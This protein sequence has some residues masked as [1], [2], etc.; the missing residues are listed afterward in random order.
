MVVGAVGGLEVLTGSR[1]GGPMIEG[2]GILLT[3]RDSPDSSICMSSEILAASPK[4]GASAGCRP[5]PEASRKSTALSNFA[6]KSITRGESNVNGMGA[7][8]SIR[9]PV[10]KAIPVAVTESLFFGVPKRDI[11]SRALRGEETPADVS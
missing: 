4:A 10:G 8:E 6:L 3:G 11:D 5:I 2:L 9:C 7:V 1:L